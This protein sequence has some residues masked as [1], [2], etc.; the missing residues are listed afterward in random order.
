MGKAKQKKKS[1]APLE[2]DSPATPPPLLTVTVPVSQT[3]RFSREFFIQEFRELAI[4]AAF[5][6]V[7]IGHVI[8]GSMVIGESM[9]P[10][11]NNGNLL[12]PDL[13]VVN[14]LAW[15]FQSWNYG[16]VVILYSPREPK[17]KLIKRLLGR[18]GDLVT[19]EGEKFCMGEGEVFIV[20][21]NLDNSYDSR[22][23]G[24]VPEGLLQGK[25]WLQVW[26]PFPKFVSSKIVNKSLITIEK[27]L[28]NLTE[29]EILAQILES[30]S[31]FLSKS[32][33]GILPEENLK[34]MLG[35]KDLVDFLSFLEK[36]FFLRAQENSSNHI[37]KL[38]PT[39]HKEAL[40]DFSTPKTL[41]HSIYWMYSRK[42]TQKERNKEH[43]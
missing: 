8:Q 39:F 42:I 36:R 15:Y 31:A 41:A 43:F 22:S 6:L 16:D 7:I 21:D 32:K 27:A 12:G 38:E 3:K 33:E 14:K 11:F 25:V 24:A 4:I 20:G 35:S 26:P 30:L 34:K 19:I 37:T 2:L 1:E 23:F 28:P 5:V 29:K 10:T 9:R 17:K 18:D 13:V 40:R